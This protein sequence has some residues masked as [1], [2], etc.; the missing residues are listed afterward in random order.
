MSSEL[1]PVKRWQKIDRLL[2]DAL[3]LEP[4]KRQGFLAQAC[5]GDEELRR[6]VRALLAAHDQAGH[7]MEKPVLDVTSRAM[8]QE[9]ET[10]VGRRLGP[11]EILSQL[12]RGGMGEV[13]RARDTRL[14]RFAAL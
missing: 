10:L 7:F 1:E 11:Y 4:I 14:D 3:R 9:S 2:D 8:E 6:E 12:G 13:Y 5:A